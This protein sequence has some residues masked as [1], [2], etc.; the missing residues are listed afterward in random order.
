VTGP[1]GVLNAGCWSVW[2]RT[3]LWRTEPLETGPDRASFHAVRAAAEAAWRDHRGHAHKTEG[4]PADRL[5]EV[6]P[7]P[8]AI[9]PGVA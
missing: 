5:V 6:G 9:L 3:C 8:P 2:C 1:Y 7:A 4:A